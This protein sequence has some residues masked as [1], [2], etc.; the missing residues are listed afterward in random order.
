M[1]KPASWFGTKRNAE[2]AVKAWTRGIANC[3]DS[4]VE[5]SLVPNRAHQPILHIYIKL[6]KCC[7][8]LYD[9][10]II[11]DALKNNGIFLNVFGPQGASYGTIK[12]FIP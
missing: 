1:A 5:P 3:R 9:T 4:D 6:R 8:E 10:F 12:L 11:A 2:K 7:L